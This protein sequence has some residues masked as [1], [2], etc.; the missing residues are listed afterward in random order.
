MY[1]YWYP[2]W[3]EDILTTIIC[4]ELFGCTQWSFE[5]P[6][7]GTRTCWTIYHSKSFALSHYTWIPCQLRLP[8][9]RPDAARGT[10]WMW[11]MPT[12]SSNV[13]ASAGAVHAS[14]L[15]LPA[16]ARSMQLGVNMWAGNSWVRITWLGP[17]LRLVYTSMLSTAAPEMLTRSLRMCCGWDFSAS[18]WFLPESSS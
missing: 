13:L 3:P 4:T 12:S 7:L 18:W 6:L 10:R 17:A 14:A 9:S 15:T 5:V 2:K 1:I 16:A 11:A 8:D